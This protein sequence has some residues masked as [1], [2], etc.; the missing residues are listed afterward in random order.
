MIISL[1]ISSFLNELKTQLAQFNFLDLAIYSPD[2]DFMTL[3]EQYVA[4]QGVFEKIP[5]EKAND[6][7]LIMWNRNGLKATDYNPRPYYRV[8]SPENLEEFKVKRASLD[9]EV[10]FVSSD[11]LKAE[12]IEEKIIL[13]FS[14]ELTFTYKIGDYEFQGDARRNLSTD[15]NS[16]EKLDIRTTGSLFSIGKTFVLDFWLLGHKKEA[17]IIEKLPLKIYQLPTNKLLD[18]VVIT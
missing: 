4:K 10:H 1:V 2:L 17:K 14:E 5:G 9:L 7:S 13:D 11:P 12:D 6:W 16:S 15:E 18:E 8:W 3:G